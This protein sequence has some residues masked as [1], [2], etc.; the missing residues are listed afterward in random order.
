MNIQEYDLMN[1]LLQTPYT[2]QRTLS[3]Q[4]GYS[5]GKVNSSLRQLIEKGYLDEEMHFEKK[6]A[7]EVERKRPR[8]AVILAAGFDLRMVPV[9]TTV[10]KGLLEVQGRPLVES[11]I[12]YLHEAGVFKIDIIVGFMKEQYEYLIDVTSG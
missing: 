6:A 7:A 4:S 11:M 9:N 8:H 2:N 12:C 10:P 3:E 1:I 5:L